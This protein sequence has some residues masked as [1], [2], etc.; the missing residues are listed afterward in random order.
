MCVCRYYILW[1]LNSRQNYELVYL[2][3]FLNNANIYFND[4]HF[5][6][7]LNYDVYILFITL[8]VGSSCRLNAMRKWFV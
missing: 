6:L 4:I 8:I 5:K 3:H 2:S 1:K 7:L